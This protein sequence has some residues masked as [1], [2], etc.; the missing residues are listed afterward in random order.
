MDPTQENVETLLSMGFPN[1]NEVRRALRLAKNDLNEAVAILTNEHPSSQFDT[2]EELDVEMKDDVSNGQTSGPV[3]GPA[4]P[5]SYE[6]LVE[7]E[8][9]PPSEGVRIDRFIHLTSTPK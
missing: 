7:S 4:P 1:E 6:E 2:L 5:P 9:L 3:Y 8:A